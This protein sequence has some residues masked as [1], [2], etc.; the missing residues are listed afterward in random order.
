MCEYKVSSRKEN[1]IIL[2]YNIRDNL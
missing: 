1:D 2:N